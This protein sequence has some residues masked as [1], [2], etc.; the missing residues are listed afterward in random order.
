MDKA[1]TGVRIVVKVQPRA[2]KTELAGKIGDAYKLR[3]A[4]P[5]VDGKANDACVRFLAERFG[6]AQS[7]VRIVQGFSSR[8]KVVEIE[9]ADPAE[10]ERILNHGS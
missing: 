7:A 9:G 2:R 8:M 5:P 6:V 1:K 4:A 3:L 10:V